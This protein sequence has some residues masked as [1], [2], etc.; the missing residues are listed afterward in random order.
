MCI[1]CVRLCGVWNG[2]VHENA[3]ASLLFVHVPQTNW[4]S[5]WAS[6]RVSVD[7]LC[8]SISLSLDV[9]FELFFYH[10]R[11][12]SSYFANCGDGRWQKQ[13][14]PNARRDRISIK[15]VCVIY[16]QLIKLSTLGFNFIV[17]WYP[18]RQITFTH[19]SNKQ[20][21][22]EIYFSIQM[23]SAFADVFI[24][25]YI[26]DGHQKSTAR[27]SKYF[28]KPIQQNDPVLFDDSPFGLE[29]WFNFPLAWW[30]SY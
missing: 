7:E 20:K 13:Y 30:K 17:R 28:N 4:L 24:F 6:E 22:N 5:E 23:L 26:L 10:S 14:K 18:S 12:H 8:V 29:T 15:F 9:C 19:T 1:V 3:F 27:K 25:N 2:T 16:R 21:T 11:C